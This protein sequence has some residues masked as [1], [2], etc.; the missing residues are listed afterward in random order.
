MER[1]RRDV[2]TPLLAAFA[3]VLLLAF[4]VFEPFL[5]VL[6]VAGCVALLLQPLQRRLRAALGDRPGLAAALLVVLS[7][8]VIMVPVVTSTLILGQRALAF[9]QWVAPRL[10][11]AELERLLTETLPARA[12]WVREWATRFEI[13]LAPM[14]ANGLNQAIA[15]ATAILQKALAGVALAALDLVLFLLSLFFLLRDGGRLRA[16]LRPVSPFSEEQEAIIVDHLGRT[17]KGALQSLLVVPLVQGLLAAL[18]FL[19]AGVPQPVAWGVAVVLAAMV[20]VL[21]SPLGWVPAVVYLWYTEPGRAWLFML[22]YGI[23]VISGIDNVVK[24]WLLRGT[25]RIHPL[26]GFLAILGGVLAFGVFGFLVGPVILSLVLSG[27]RI[28]RLDVL[29]ASPPAP[30]P[31]EAPLPAPAPLPVA[32]PS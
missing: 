16:A 14:L 31:A 30:S 11:P 19:F 12:P 5:L 13:Q 6:A 1:R 8:V 4:R 3:V 17:V 9:F 28:Y 29:R 2:L 22:I 26:L 24:P 25:A 21:G 27:L 15:A 23:V 7:T 10:Q 20:P 32:P 18:G